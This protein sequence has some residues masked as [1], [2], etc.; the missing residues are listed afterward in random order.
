MEKQEKGKK[1][2][3]TKRQP[4]IVENKEES[5][6]VVVCRDSLSKAEQNIKSSLI[7]GGIYDTVGDIYERNRK[8][9][10]FNLVIVNSLLVE[11]KKQKLKFLLETIVHLVKYLKLLETDIYEY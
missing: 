3:K 8:Y 2:S 11:E 1:G 10:I 6:P 4:K 5:K 9:I 7:K